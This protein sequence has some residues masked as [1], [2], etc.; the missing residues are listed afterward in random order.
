MPDMGGTATKPWDPSW[1]GLRRVSQ[2]DRS[3]AVPGHSEPFDSAQDKLPEESRVPATAFSDTTF[4]P[5]V[6]SSYHT[7]GITDPQS[8]HFPSW[9]RTRR[10]KYP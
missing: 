8:G 5:P 2:D 9:S 7:P 3:G 6:K 1:E 10:M 4:D